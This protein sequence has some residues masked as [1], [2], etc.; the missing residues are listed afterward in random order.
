M[1]TINQFQ[2]IPLIQ[3]IAFTGWSNRTNSVF[4]NGVYIP[5][6]LAFN[7]PALLLSQTNTSVSVY[8]SLGLYSRNGSTLSLANTA[9]GSFNSTT[10][11]LFWV[12]LATSATQNITPGNWYLAVYISNNPSNS[13]Y[14]V[15]VNSGIGGAGNPVYG[16]VVVNGVQATTLGVMAATI[17]TSDVNKEPGNLRGAY[18]YVLITA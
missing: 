1:A 6:T 13:N 9:S 17:H 7:T 4:F 14:S 2:N 16:G 10:N 5:G 15:V 3:Q 12:S 18:P 11:D 8:V